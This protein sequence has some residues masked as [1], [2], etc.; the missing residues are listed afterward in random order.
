[1]YFEG[2]ELKPFG[3]FT[4]SSDLVVENVYF[5]I[6]FLDDALSSLRLLA[7]SEVQLLYLRLIGAPLLSSCL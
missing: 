4:R 1:M 2:R 7:K 5:R 6:S 3:E